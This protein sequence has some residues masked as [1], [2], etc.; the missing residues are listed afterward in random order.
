MR[1]GKMKGKDLKTKGKNNRR[2]KR[3]KGKC[4]NE[5]L[6]EADG[7]EKKKWEKGRLQLW[8][9]DAMS[10]IASRDFSAAASFAD[11]A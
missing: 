1:T 2:E 6:K 11:P 9:D 8:L 3:K 7:R 4:K 5:M 10:Y